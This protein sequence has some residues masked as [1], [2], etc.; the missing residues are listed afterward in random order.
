MIAFGKKD[1]IQ[2]HAPFLIKTDER[3]DNC[4]KF[5]V[6]LAQRGEKGSNIN[7]DDKAV[8]SILM[9]CYPLSPDYNEVY[10]ITFEGYILH[11]TRNESY[12]LWDDYEVREGKYFIEFTRSRLLN[13]LPQMIDSDLMDVLT[14]PNEAKHYGIYCENHIIDIISCYEPEIKKLD[15]IGGTI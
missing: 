5:T 6:A 14:S 3:E 12:C 8:E 10:E 1:A 2:G 15:N 9:N 7:S 13:I 11:Q 4:V